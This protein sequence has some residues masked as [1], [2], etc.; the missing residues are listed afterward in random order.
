[1]PK[2]AYQLALAVLVGLVAAILTRDNVTAVNSRF[3]TAFDLSPVTPAM[4][5]DLTPITVA[6]AVDAAAVGEPAPAVAAVAASACAN[7]AGL[8][9]PLHG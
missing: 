9:G 3:V 2:F 4:F 7:P 6:L 8:R 5:P 1:V